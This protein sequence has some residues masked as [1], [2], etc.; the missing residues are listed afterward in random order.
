METVAAAP[1]DIQVIV[2]GECFP[3]KKLKALVP[4]SGTG[5]AGKP[6][7]TT[8]TGFLEIGEWLSEEDRKKLGKLMGFPKDY[9]AT[10]FQILVNVPPGRRLIC[11]C[12]H[13]G[14]NEKRFYFTQLAD[15]DEKPDYPCG[16]GSGEGLKARDGRASLGLQEDAPDCP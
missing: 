12:P 5:T 8:Y 14:F 4:S 7:S 13:D 3:A 15:L 9:P 10:V 1:G 11:E 2:Y 6:L 16:Q